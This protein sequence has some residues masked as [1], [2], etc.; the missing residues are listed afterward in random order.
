MLA[1]EIEDLKVRLGNPNLPLEK[2]VIC[3]EL[4]A[5]KGKTGKQTAGT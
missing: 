1:V 2:S 5:R 3:F 4:S